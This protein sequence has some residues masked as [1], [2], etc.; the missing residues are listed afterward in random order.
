MNHQPFESWLL[1]DLPLASE[2][3]R[4]LDSHLRTCPR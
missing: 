4:E 2:Q 1:D 3:R